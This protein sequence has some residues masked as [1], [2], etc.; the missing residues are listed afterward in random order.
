[1]KIFRMILSFIICGWFVFVLDFISHVAERLC[2]DT[3][4]IALCI[5]GVKDER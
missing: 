1:M 4:Q 2:N 3:A 5:A